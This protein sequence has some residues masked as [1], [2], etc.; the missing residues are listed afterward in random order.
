MNSL[1]MGISS[2]GT[3]TCVFNVYGLPRRFKAIL[4]GEFELASLDQR[5]EISRCLWEFTV[6]GIRV[7]HDPPSDSDDCECSEV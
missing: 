3:R 2:T 5:A 7:A 6:V 1:T 4:T